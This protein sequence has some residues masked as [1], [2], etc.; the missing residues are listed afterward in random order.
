MGENWHCFNNLGGND[1]LLKPVDKLVPTDL[2]SLQKFQYDIEQ[3]GS[4]LILHTLLVEEI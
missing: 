4:Y 2:A 1:R 3:I